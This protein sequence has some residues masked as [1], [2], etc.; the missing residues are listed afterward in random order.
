MRFRAFNSMDRD[1]MGE[2]VP[3]VK[4]YKC[5]ADPER[6]SFPLDRGMNR[7]MLRASVNRRTV[8]LPGE[9]GRTFC[10]MG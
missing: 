10:G 4:R 7:T 2:L 6:T 8:L 9:R 5:V 3:F 1:S